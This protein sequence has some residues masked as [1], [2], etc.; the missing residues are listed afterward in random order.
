MDYRSNSGEDRVWVHLS[1]SEVEEAI[2]R[3]VTAEAEIEHTDEYEIGAD[4]WMVPK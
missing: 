2:R 1:Q 4:A 3:Y